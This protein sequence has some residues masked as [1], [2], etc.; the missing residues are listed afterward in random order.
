MDYGS[1][2]KCINKVNIIVYNDVGYYTG[3]S[4]DLFHASTKINDLENKLDYNIE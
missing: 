1:L 4:Q 3:V 2:I